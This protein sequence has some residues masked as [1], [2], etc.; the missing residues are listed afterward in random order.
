MSD[1]QT[2]LTQIR[3]RRMHS[4]ASDQGLHCLQIAQP[5]FFRNIHIIQPDIPKI[6]NGLFQ[7]IV[8]DGLF[9]L[10][11]INH[12]HIRAQLFKANDVVS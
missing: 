8:W 6:E 10:Q 1:R 12:F 9:N 11:W 2:V 4:A 7:Y 3:R 5:F